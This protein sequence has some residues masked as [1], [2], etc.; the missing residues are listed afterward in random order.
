M[1]LAKAIKDILVPAPKKPV[2]PNVEIQTASND[3]EGQRKPLTKTA[4][5]RIYRRPSSFVEKLPWYEFQN[6]SQTMLLDDGKSVGAVFDIIP[7]ATEGRSYNWLQNRRD[8]IQDALQDCFEEMTAGPWIIQ[9]YTYDD[10]NLEDYIQK[11]R[12]YPKHYCR[13][14]SFT[15]E[16]LRTM[17]IHLR[18]ICKEGGLFED[19]EVLDAPWSGGQRR[20]K[21]AVYRRLPEKWKSYAGMTPE[22]ELNDT[23]EKLDAAFRD[24]GIGLVRNGGK[25]VYEWLLKWFNPRPE[26]TDGDRQKFVELAS[27][28]DEESLPA[29]D[30]FAE[31]LFFALPKSDAPSQT[32]WFDGLPHRC[33]R[34]HKIRRTPKIGQIA[35]EVSATTP[36]GLS[37]GKA[38]CMMDKMPPGTMIAT[39]IIVT[40]QDEVQNHINRIQDKSKGESVD[41]TMTR[42]DC[43]VAKSLMGNKHKI[44]RSMMCVYLRGENLKDLRK[45]TNAASTILLTNQLAP[46][47][48]EDES[49]GLDAYIY[50]LPMVY[51]PSMDANFKATRPVWAQHLA[52]LAS[53]FGRHRGTGNPGQTAFNR[54]GE[55]VSYDPFNGND[56]KKNAHG[57]ILGPTGA[58]KSAHI[59]NMSAQI[60]ALQ[61]PRLF[62]VEAGNSFGLLADYFASQGLSVNKIQLK[63]GAGVSLPPF[64]DADQMLSKD[65][66]DLLGSRIVSDSALVGEDD[67]IAHIPEKIRIGDITKSYDELTEAERKDV[68]ARAAMDVLADMMMDEDSGSDDE[69]DEQR[70]IMGE[71]EIVATLMITGG[72]EEEAKKLTR[73]DRRMIRDAIL[74]GAKL[75]RSEGRR[76]MTSD[77]SEGFR[78]ITKDPAY[79][80]HRQSRAFEMGES[81]RMFCDGFEGEVF[82]TDG[83]GWPDTDVTIV[84]LATFAREGYNAQLAIAYTSIMMRINNLAEKHQHDERPIVMLTD[85]GHI[86]TTNPLLAPFVV[87]VVKMWR[88]LGAWWWVAT[89]NMGDFPNSARK[90]LNMIEWWIAL[91]M[92]Q[93]EIEE[94]AR[95]KNLSIEQKQL[96]LSARKEPKKYTE[97]VVLSENME[98]LFRNVPPS[99]YLSLAGTEKDEKTERAKYMRKFGITEVEA[100]EYVGKMID[101]Y[102]G[103]APK[104]ADPV[105]AAN[106]PMS[107][108]RV[109]LE[110]LEKLQSEQGQRV[111]AKEVMETLR[112]TVAEE[113]N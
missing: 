47:R 79:P 71:M 6:E 24:A 94:I 69:G 85:E 5:K 91:V 113:D 111:V 70:D 67:L 101:F 105:P 112:A 56:R 107:Q 29:G 58:G 68:R 100:A 93:D 106:N 27:Y 26:L 4:V 98:A 52:N 74:N 31:S 87:K 72:E 13:D 75:A 48:E 104:P 108:A 7:I 3:G 55:P 10:D 64:V 50:N 63:P 84:D 103:I 37:T 21:L 17:E 53:L 11:L 43:E 54:G 44:Y 80:E 51:E 99:L 12:L 66:E 25:E 73:A 96:M 92:P 9:Q 49:L 61:R 83:D 60:M 23:I 16:W 95:F 1:D 33:L 40:P 110:R 15:Q 20:I 82:N 65:E 14:S 45:K 86:I 39:T 88:K 77:V 34:V 89:Q 30:D 28:P 2:E 81:L 62:I 18:G 109:T 42:E 76:T 22:E 36:D 102:R 97:G 90:M 32:W 41:A 46:V 78:M 35:G 38:S 8:M 19:K 57:L 59:T